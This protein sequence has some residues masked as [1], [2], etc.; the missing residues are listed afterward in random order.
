MKK[1]KPH[2]V[3][4][5]KLQLTMATVV[6][7]LVVI[8]SLLQAVANLHQEFVPIKQLVVDNQ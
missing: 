8:L 7:E 2:P 1:P 6:L 5:G 4:W 3:A